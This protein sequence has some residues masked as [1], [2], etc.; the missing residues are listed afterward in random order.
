MGVIFLILVGTIFGWQAAILA[1]SE[2]GRSVSR[3]IAI[4]ILGALVAG[5]V[6]SPWIGFGDLVS[7]S[8][9]IGAL[10]AGLAGSAGLL[11]IVHLLRHSTIQRDAGN[12]IPRAPVRSVGGGARMNPRGEER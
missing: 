2:D 4:G 9:D 11:L 10:L 6:I 8:Y 12:K 5:L 1:Q 7:G 3:N